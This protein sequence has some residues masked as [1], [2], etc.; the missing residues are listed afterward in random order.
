MPFPPYCRLSSPCR[1]SF[2][3]ALFSTSSVARSSEGCGEE[4]TSLTTRLP[5]CHTHCH[6]HCHTHRHTHHHTHRHTRCHPCCHAG[7]MRSSARLQTVRWLQTASDEE[8]LALRSAAL[9]CK[10]VCSCHLSVVVCYTMFIRLMLVICLILFSCLR[11][12][13]AVLPSV[14]VCLCLHLCF[15]RYSFVLLIFVFC[16]GIKLNVL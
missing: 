10:A 11:F 1:S 3:A 12:L 14:V 7:A 6:M 15:L 9:H 13:F 16:V 4:G 8:A 5:H 2:W